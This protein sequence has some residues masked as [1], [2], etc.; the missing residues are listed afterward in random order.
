VHQFKPKFIEAALL[1]DPE[2]VIGI[3]KINQQI[4][5]LAPAINGPAIADAVKIDSSDAA[6]P[7][8]ATVRRHEGAI[9][10]F[11]VAM[12]DGAATATFRVAGVTGKATARVL[13]ENREVALAGGA[14]QD[15]FRPWDVHLYQIVPK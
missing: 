2:M 11:A 6:I 15:S 13:G 10:V 3:Q 1:A 8:E 9:Y 12:R 5:T 4:H 14:F 7:V